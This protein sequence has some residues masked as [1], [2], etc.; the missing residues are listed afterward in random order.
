MSGMIISALMAL[1]LYAFMHFM[2]ARAV[3]QHDGSSYIKD[4]YDRK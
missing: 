4:D 3:S 1:G 2:T